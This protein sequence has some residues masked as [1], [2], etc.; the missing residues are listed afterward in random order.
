[1]QACRAA[2]GQ[3]VSILAVLM[4][5]TAGLLP[6]QP[7]SAQQPANPAFNRLVHL[8]DFCN[9]YHPTLHSS[10]LVTPQWVGDPEV[11]AVITLGID[12]MRDPDRY[13][14]YLRP[15]LD[16]LKK[17]DGR[18]AVSIMTCTVDP[19]HPRLQTWLEEGLSIECHTVDHPCPCL[20][21]GDFDQAKN[22]YDRCVDL[23]FDIPG[24][25][26]VAFRFP[27]MDSLNT[28][29]PRAYAE[30]I[31]QTTP[32]GRFLQLSTSVTCL[33][34]PADPAI[35][36]H[37]EI[38]GR[39]A[40]E[41]FRK[42]VPFPSFVNQIQNYP[43]PYL[44]G[45][46]CWEFPCTIPDDWQGQNIHRPHN[47]RTVA[48]LKAAIDA[49][50]TKQ[51][52]ANIVFHPHGWIRAEQIVEVIDHVQHQYG[53]RVKFLTFRE[54]LDRINQHL[55]DG[56]PVRDPGTGTDNGV[57]ILDLN[58][59]GYEDVFVGNEKARFYKLW[60]PATKSWTSC[61]HELMARQTRFGVDQQQ[62]VAIHEEQP[63]KFRWSTFSR[64]ARKL[65]Q[66]SEPLV[67]DPRTTIDHLRLRDLD[68]DG[69][70]EVIVAA[71][72]ERSILQVDRSGD[73]PSFRRQGKFPAAIADQEG[74]DLGL[75]WVDLDE[76][77]FD[78]LLLSNDQ[79]SAVYL[80]DSSSFRFNEIEPGT[81]LPPIAIA[82]KNNG[83]WFANGHL[84]LQNEHTH[85][86]PDGVDRR[87]FQQILAK[88]DPPPKSPEAGLRSLKVA[89]EFQVELMAAEP[90]T[91][92][93]VALEWGLDGKLWIV[94]MADYPMGIDD[95]GK[96]GG[97][98]RYLEDT[99]GDGRYDRSTLFVDQIPFPTGVLPINI[100]PQQPACLI[101]AAPH[102]VRATR[103]GNWNELLAAAD[104]VL[105]S[106]FTEGNQQHR[107]NG[108][109]PGLDNWLY[110]ANGDSGGVIQDPAG[111][112]LDIRG[113]DLRIK[114]GRPLQV[115][116]QTGQT[117]FGRHCDA[118]GNWFGCSNPIPLRH[119]LLP[120]HYLKRNPHYRY[121]A[122]R[123]DIATAANTEVFPRSRVLSHWS[124]YQP[125]AAGQPHRFTSACSTDFYRDSLLG[126]AFENNSFTCEPV[127][128]LV[129]RRL[130]VPQGLRF[131][132]TRPPEESN[133]EFLAS[134]DS[135]FRPATV[136]TGPDGA[137]WI[138]D[139]Y[140]L[141]IEHP[142]WIDDQQEKELFLR[143]GHD[144]GRIYRVLPVHKE[145]RGLPTG[146]LPEP[147]LRDGKYSRELT[148]HLLNMLTVENRWYLETAQR[149][150]VMISDQA[151]D[152]E[153]PQKLERLT[154]QAAPLVRLHA[155]ATLDGRDEIQIEHLVRVLQDPH[156]AIRRHAIRMSER[157][158]P[159]APAESLTGLQRLLHDKDLPVRLQLAFSLG[160]CP[161]PAASSLLATLGAA[162]VPAEDQ[163]YLRA[164]VFSS[165]HA[166][167]IAGVITAAQS[168]GTHPEFVMALLEQASRFGKPE[169][170]RAS[171]QRLLDADPDAKKFSTRELELIVQIQAAFAAE[172]ID[173]QD[174]LRVAARGFAHKMALL[175]QATDSRRRKQAIIQLVSRSPFFD[176]SE[177]I[178]GLTQ[179]IHPQ[180]DLKRQQLAVAELAAI[181]AP[182]VGKF[183]IESWRSV[184]PTIRDEM[185]SAVLQRRAWS[186]RFLN[187]IISGDIDRGE[188]SSSQQGRLRGHPDDAIAR[189]AQELFAVTGDR[190][191]HQAV[192]TY[193]ARFAEIKRDFDPFRGLAV[194]EKHCA[195]C[196]RLAEV[197]TMIG[198]DLATIKDPSTESLLT[199][200]LQPNLAVEDKYRTYAV[201]LADGRVLAGLIQS[202]STTQI[203]LANTQG[204]KIEL[205]RN[206]IERIQSTGQSLMP[207]GLDREIDT[208]AM[209]DLIHFVQQSIRQSTP[210]LKP[211]SFTGNQPRRVEPDNQGRLR[212]A[213]TTCEI[214]GSEIMFEP[215]YE[216]L[217]FWG[218]ADDRALWKFEIQREGRY[219]VIVEYACPDATAGNEFV[220]TI[221]E[222][223]LK[224]KVS[225]TGSWDRYVRTRVGTIELKPGLHVAQL[226]AVGP[227]QGYLFD[228]KAVELIPASTK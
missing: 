143:A 109:S 208:D 172:P 76:D 113:R 68:Q 86:L 26:P 114:L 80:F 165:L 149:F 91:M 29:S 182:A 82:G 78:D 173:P 222:D 19:A 47:P 189:Q 83:A 74:N 18:A 81:D 126:P 110:L 214:Y 69:Q 104:N 30:I 223:S 40:A 137:V 58:G 43:Y 128:N 155:L 99:D 90:L 46:G 195:R 97:R 178:D 215:R 119:Y 132:S 35:Q 94:E 5:L 211:K 21:G 219:E 57:R 33:L 118:W 127:H 129:H 7:A 131:S 96:P 227:L 123:I 221:G 141:V 49:T 53:K 205:L 163:V 3:T 52:V 201:E 144:R 134:T 210:Q 63:G 44:I 62:V 9:P 59:D 95:R 156:P 51:G 100:D 20:Q 175:G 184:S 151:A 225:S 209:F 87:S 170:T 133:R 103:P 171:L 16:R 48:D 194:F 220:L 41:R 152:P 213:A 138:A 13:E 34:T 79:K 23:M 67:L 135:W 217:G 28:P 188:V 148:D 12:D 27:C 142:E 112:P 181:D 206:Q 2:L 11:E 199:A 64:D 158:L 207:T 203:D 56:Q 106:G 145:P 88:T 216:N 54:C 160:A 98:V 1:M 101:T 70:V 159:D 150:L 22:T 92:D 169:L 17:I 102:L 162:D 24:N 6:G 32:R 193:L 72:H 139:M 107:Y 85:R 42:Y 60:N 136:K 168:A 115:E 55:L 212:L 111:Q 187:A 10:R 77:G 185:L 147:I 120:D 38:D 196:H 50:V 157:F 93:P 191:P 71:P 166:E 125:P 36:R 218:H 167:N 15:I 180:V 179:L 39:F 174:E 121:P 122:P 130:L 65:Q 8:D 176:P 154:N 117:Q 105:L 45:N 224:R 146:N 226:Q 186:A 116:L 14:A 89:D 37:F 153:L 183:F 177:K 197:G 124:G 204:Q 198:P 75:R 108:F 84:W 73:Q 25:R 66:S 164:A 202:E 161:D 200:I 190:S 4:P 140:R 228:L 31:Q 192:A 61:K